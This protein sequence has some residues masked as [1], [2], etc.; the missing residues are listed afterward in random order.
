MK[1]IVRFA[2]IDSFPQYIVP[3]VVDPVLFHYVKKGRRPSAPVFLMVGAWAPI[4]RPLLVMEA[5]VSVLERFPEAKLRIVGYGQQWDKMM[6]FVQ[7]QGLEDNILLLGSMTKSM[8]AREMRGSD[9]LVHASQYETFSVVCAEALCSGL[10]VIASRVG[11]IPEF[12]C[13]SN[14]IL[15][16]NSLDAWRDAFCIF[17]G[18]E[19]SWNYAQISREAVDRFS[20]KMVGAKFADIYQQIGN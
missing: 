18:K 13:S 1:D 11:G 20:L 3:N 17:I 8:I 9:C 7:D 5:F 19:Y 14:G 12:V 10:P 15:V 4:K 2:G 16:E 6:M